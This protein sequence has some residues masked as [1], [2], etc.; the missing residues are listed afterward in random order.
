MRNKKHDTSTY[1]AMRERGLIPA[2]FAGTRARLRSIGIEVEVNPDITVT[3][4]AQF[5]GPV[6]AVLVAEADPCSEEARVWALKKAK[7]D[8]TFAQALEAMTRLARIDRHAMAFF[9]Q[10]GW[11]AEGETDEAQ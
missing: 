8:P 7:D 5:W 1:A 2:R 6:W 10:E 11:D 3:G 4:D 9:I